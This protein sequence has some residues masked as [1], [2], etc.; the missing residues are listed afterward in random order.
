MSFK[1]NF[2]ISSKYFHKKDYLIIT[3]SPKTYRGKEVKLSKNF[4]LIF[5][6]EGIPLYL[7]VFNASDILKGTRFALSHIKNMDILIDVNEKTIITDISI[8][9][10]NRNKQEKFNFHYETENKE[11]I[12]PI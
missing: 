6:K 11:N 10:N 9:L 3:I 7:E 1:T 8:I 5:N 4:N 12:P 2:K